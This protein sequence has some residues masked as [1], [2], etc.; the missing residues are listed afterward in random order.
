MDLVSLQITVAGKGVHS[1]T[2]AGSVLAECSHVTAARLFTTEFRSSFACTC[3][4]PHVM[5]NLIATLEKYELNARV[6][7]KLMNN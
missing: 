6:K 7:V 3:E 1:S 4:G 2:P 5:N